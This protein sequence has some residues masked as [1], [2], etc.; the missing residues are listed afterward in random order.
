MTILLL[1]AGVIFVGCIATAVVAA[2]RSD[3]DGA[4]REVASLLALLVVLLV[5]GYGVQSAVFG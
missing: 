1:I 3:I 5:I 4:G 2:Y